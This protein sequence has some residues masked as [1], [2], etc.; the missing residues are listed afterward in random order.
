LGQVSRQPILR[1]PRCITAFGR[2]PRSIHLCWPRSKQ[3]A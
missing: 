1:C 2:N 3:P